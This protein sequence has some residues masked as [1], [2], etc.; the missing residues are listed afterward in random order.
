VDVNAGFDYFYGVLFSPDGDHVTKSYI[1]S[2]LGVT[3]QVNT[4][5]TSMAPVGPLS[6]LSVALTSGQTLFRVGDVTNLQRAIQYSTGMN[7]SFSLMPISIPAGVSLEYE[8]Q[9]AAGFYPIVIWNLNKNAEGNPND[10]IIKGFEKLAESDDSTYA[11][12]YSRQMAQQLLPFMKTIPTSQ[13][14]SDFIQNKP[15]NRIHTLIS[16]AEQWL[17]TGETSELPENLKPQIDPKDIRKLMKPIQSATNCGFEV[18]YKRGYD[19]SGRD[20]TIYA[21]CVETITGEVREPVRIVLT[22]EEISGL[23]EGSKPSD[24][25][26]VD[27]IFDTSPETYLTSKSTEKTVKIKDGKAVYE[28]IQNFDLPL[29]IGVRVA[30]CKATGN[31]NLELCR[32]VILFK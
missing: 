26:G 31:K 9:V 22:S 7:T 14:V 1:D 6:Q 24:F 18:G 32:R 27:V 15:N 13:E 29:I 2:L 5:D 28:I 21:D 3:L 30:K 19:A 17:Q 4:F 23:V 25:E 12:I 10:E 8:S 16:E 20:D 11:G